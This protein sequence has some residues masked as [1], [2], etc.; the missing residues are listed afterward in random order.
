MGE[1]LGLRERWFGDLDGEDVGTYNDVWPLDL[2]V[3]RYIDI[4][5]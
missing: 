4:G 5:K 3:S 1:E 2:E